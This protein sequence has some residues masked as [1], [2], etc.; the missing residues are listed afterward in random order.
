[1]GCEESWSG[2]ALAVPGDTKG[3]RIQKH[4]LAK[5]VHLYPVLQTS[6]V[7]ESCFSGDG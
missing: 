1:M 2:K 3:S 7:V 5:S 6:H 4:A